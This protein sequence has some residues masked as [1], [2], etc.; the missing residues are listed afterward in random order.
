MFLDSIALGVELSPSTPLG[1]SVEGEGMKASI[2]LTS[3]GPVG[4]QG[5]PSGDFRVEL[6]LLGTDGS[7]LRSRRARAARTVTVNR[8]APVPKLHEFAVSCRSGCGLGGRPGG[9][10]GVL[11]DRIRARPAG[12]RISAVRSVVLCARRDLGGAVVGL[13]HARH[14]QLGELRAHRSR[15]FDRGRGAESALRAGYAGIERRAP[16]VAAYVLVVGYEI[17]NALGFW[18]SPLKPVVLRSYVF[19]TVIEHTTARPGIVGF[20]FY[21]LAGVVLILSCGLLAQNLRAHRREALIAL[22][23]AFV[24]ALAG[25][26]DILLVTG[27]LSDTLYLLPHGFLV[28]AFGVATTLVLRYRAT[29]GALAETTTSLAQATEE[30]RHSHAELIQVQTELSSKQQLAAVG[31]L[32]AAIAH[33]VRNPLAVIV[34]AVAGL[35]R[36][37]LREEDRAMLLGIVDEET[38]RLN[39]L[40]TDLLRFA[41][42]VNVQL[43]AVSL[44]ELA[45]RSEVL[46][47]DG[48]RSRFKP[49]MTRPCSS[50]CW[51]LGSSRLV[52]DSLVENAFQAMPSGGTVRIQIRRGELESRSCVNIAISDNGHG[53]DEAVLERG[54]HPFFTTRPSGTGLGLPIVQRIV[55]AHGGRLELES[56]PG[57]GTTAR[58]L[59]PFGQPE[60]E[61]VDSMAGVA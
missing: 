46:A 14:R 21:V 2:G 10:R 49:T 43:A 18:W 61:V 15:R 52:L 50:W 24:L 60:P 26:N 7:P 17:A 19:G 33:E 34:N 32:A 12:S 42:P 54:L 1:L 44:S 13:C 4:I 58:V 35:R 31:E 27:V 6:V 37:G 40:V 41:R 55:E 30:L 22:I 39:R 45:Q 38:A 56:K 25:V 16:V 8:D 23:G 48:H 59:I 51:M 20:S 9:D 3:A 47:T 29:A 11:F 36:P 5:L 28:Y 53:M 57:V